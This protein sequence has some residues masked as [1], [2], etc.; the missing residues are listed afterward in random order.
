MPSIQVENVSLLENAR[1]CG[2]GICH[3]RDKAPKFGLYN[4]VSDY[5]SLIH[6]M[7]GKMDRPR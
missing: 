4:G 5:Q 1:C 3:W 7:T 6:N 2:G